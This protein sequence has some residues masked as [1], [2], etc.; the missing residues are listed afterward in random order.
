MH[1]R[2]AQARDTAEGAMCFPGLVS[3]RR[4]LLSCVQEVDGRLA[5]PPV[6]PAAFPPQD[7]VQQWTERLQRVAM[8]AQVLLE[9]LCWLLRCCPG[10]APGPRDPAPDPSDLRFPSP[11]PEAQL[12]SGCLM[13]RQDPHWQRSTARLTEMLE[14]VKAVKADVDRVR[15][16]SCEALFHS[17]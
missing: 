11:A 9:Q 12:P 7:A 8:Q 15:Q 10:P 6:Y 14:T 17:W 3:L 16:Q 13:R 4:N 2:L 5:G 1:A